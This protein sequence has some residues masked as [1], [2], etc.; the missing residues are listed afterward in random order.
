MQ[1][2]SIRF[3]IYT[4]LTSIYACFHINIVRYLLLILSIIGQINHFLHSLSYQSSMC[5]QYILK[6]DAPYKIELN[7]FCDSKNDM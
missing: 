3:R 5:P 1:Q 4:A 2:S 6:M 7:G